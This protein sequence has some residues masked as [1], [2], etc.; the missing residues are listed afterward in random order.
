MTQGRT[1]GEGHQTSRQLS[2]ASLIII[3]GQVFF[4]IN[5]S[6]IHAH[7]RCF[8]CFTLYFSLYA[9][10]HAC[11]VV[12]VCVCV[13]VCLPLGICDIKSFIICIYF[14]NSIELHHNVH[15]VHGAA[16]RP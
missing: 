9:F 13:C 7:L 5:V 10:V 8:L 16:C 11:L 14:P 1:L 3:L 2:D 4:K 12:C 6:E 15:G